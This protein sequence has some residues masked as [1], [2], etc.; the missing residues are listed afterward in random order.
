MYYKQDIHALVSKA[1]L[2]WSYTEPENNLSQGIQKLHL[3][4]KTMKKFT[5]VISVNNMLMI[6]LRPAFNDR[7]R[8]IFHAWVP[9]GDIVWETFAL[10]SQYHVIVSL[11][12]VILGCDFLYISLALHMVSQLRMLSHELKHM[13][14]NVDVELIRKCV[15]QHQLMLS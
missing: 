2:F 6:G 5:L 1:K 4:I 13:V 15:R 11:I 12:P 10:F 7:T 14:N 8:F 9:S 3:Y